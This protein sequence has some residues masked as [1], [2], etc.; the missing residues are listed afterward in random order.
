VSG[1][2]I[3][4]G[5]RSIPTLSDLGLIALSALMGLFMVGMR[6]RMR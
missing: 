6:R 5:P 3:P 1:G 2:A 4:V